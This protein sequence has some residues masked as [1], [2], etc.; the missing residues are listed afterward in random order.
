MMQLRRRIRALI[1]DSSRR[2]AIHTYHSLALA[3]TERSM[4]ARA[5]VA[6]EGEVDF[7]GIVE[8]AN[9]RLRGEEDIVGAAPDELRDRLLDGFEYVL[10]DEY[11]DI[12]AAQYELISHIARRPGDVSE[13]RATILAVGD[14]DQTI[15]EWR[16]ANVK[17]LRRFEAEY[18][19]KCH[20]LV[21]NY[22]ST[23][24]IVEAAEALIGHNQDRMKTGHPIRVDERRAQGSPGGDWASLDPVGKGRVSVL[25][26]ADASV[27]PHAV[28]AEIERL[29]GLE[30]AA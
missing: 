30:S 15:Y 16:Y 1:G 5:S 19:A 2:V 25:E 13:D 21:E 20:Y 27:E 14:D 8:E 24:N 9:R 29:R 10:V 11:Q 23:R 6:A 26:V 4:A 22:R 17:F 28:L 7:D 3:L 12:D 18:E